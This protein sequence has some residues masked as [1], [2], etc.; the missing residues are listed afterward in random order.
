LAG[1]LPADK[2]DGIVFL[3]AHPS[4]T[5]T[6][7]RA[8][9]AA[10]KRE[11]RPDHLDKAL[12][13]F[14]PKNGFN[15]NGDSIFS[16]KFVEEYSIAQSRRMNNLIAE[17]LQIRASI[18]A[19]QHVPT[20]DDAFIFYRTSA[21][22]SNFSTGVHCC[23]LQPRKLL[24]NDG[25]IDASQI[26]RTVRVPDPGVREDDASFGGTKFLTLTSFLSANAIRSTHSLNDIDWCSSNNSV[27]CAVE[28]ISVPILV[29]AM[30]GH[31]FIRDGEH[32]Y[33]S[34]ASLD[35]EFVAVQGANHGLSP[36]T[37]C[38][39]LHGGADF[40]NARINLFNYIRDWVTPRF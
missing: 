25:T 17:A 28:R 37:P 4:N 35:K 24:K 9:N 10:V 18:E 20:D 2:A 33:E 6:T 30:Q 5:I 36:C 3:D 38:S 16:S 40:S 23:T 27:P 19:G 8:I 26:I 21:R 29:M 32:I 22:L 12:D 39:A 34:A 1:F 13:P 14:N 31:Y 15:P 11:D 7:L